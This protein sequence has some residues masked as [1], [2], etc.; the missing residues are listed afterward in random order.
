MKVGTQLAL[1]KFSLKLQSLVWHCLHRGGE[2]FTPQ[3]NF[4]QNSLRDH[5]K[6]MSLW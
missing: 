4:S 3:V 5:A 1:L 2:V 6:Y